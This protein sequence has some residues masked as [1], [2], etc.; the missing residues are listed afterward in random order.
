MINCVVQYSVGS[1]I[2]CGYS[3]EA[4]RLGVG[5]FLI[6]LLGQPALM[7][8]NP[9]VVDVSWVWVCVWQWTYE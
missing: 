4:A 7:T 2:K 8:D 3:V 6:D 1:T 5:H 9:E